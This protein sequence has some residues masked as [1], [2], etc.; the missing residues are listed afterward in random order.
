[1]ANVSFLID[2]GLKWLHTGWIPDFIVRWVIRRLCESRKRE[3]M[4]NNVETSYEYLNGFIQKLRQSPIAILSHKANEQHYELAPK[5][6]QLVLGK[7][8]KYSACYFPNP[9]SSLD[10]AEQYTLDLYM[11]RAQIADGQVILDLGC[12]WGSFTLYVAEKYPNCAIVSLTNSSLQQEYIQNVCRQKGYHH[13]QV[14]QADINEWDNP[15]RFSF[16]RVVSVEMFEHM[17]NYELLL[18]KI[19]TWLKPNGYLFLHIFC[20]RQFPYSFESEGSQNWMGKYFFSGGTMPSAF[21]LLYFQ[22]SH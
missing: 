6:F 1:M 10:E 7:H 14:I 18:N 8:L 22:A 2:I 12:G 3:L 20:H 4:T 11:E 5:F 13:I 17:K 9:Y 16:D 15:Q 21:L 19:A